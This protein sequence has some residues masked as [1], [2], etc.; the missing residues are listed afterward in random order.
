MWDVHGICMGL[1]LDLFGI[2]DLYGIYMG[3]WCVNSF[4]EG[5][6]STRVWL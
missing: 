3:F 6:W 2:Y 5:I 4:L 1:I